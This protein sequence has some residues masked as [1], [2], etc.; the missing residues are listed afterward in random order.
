MAITTTITARI[1]ADD[2]RTVFGKS[3]LSGTGTLTNGTGTAT[4]SPVTLNVGNNNIDVTGLGTFTIVLPTGSTGTATSDVCTV[5][6][7]PVSLVAGSQVITTQGVIGNIVV[8]FNGVKEGDVVVSGL[9][10]VNS[11][12]ITVKGAAQQGCAV[13]E[14]FPLLSNTVTCEVETANSTF[15]WMAR[16]IQ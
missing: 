11:F 10:S 1:Y 2:R 14:D 16:G 6:G 8:A 5:A 15:Y 7:S 4:G 13:N 12:G 9:K 3:V